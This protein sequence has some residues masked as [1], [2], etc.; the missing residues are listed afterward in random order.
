MRR[1]RAAVQAFFISILLGSSVESDPRTRRFQAHFRPGTATH[2]G[3]GARQMNHRC[4][5]GTA[6]RTKSRSQDRSCRAV[7]S[8]RRSTLRGGSARRPE[9]KV[10]NTW[11]PWRC[12]AAGESEI[13]HGRCRRRT[14]RSFVEA[15]RPGTPTIST[16]SSP[17]LI[18]TSSGIPPLSRPWRAG[19][20]PTRGHDGA[21]K[22]WD[23]YRGGAWERSTIRIQEIRDLGESV[24]VLG[25]I[26]LTARTTGIEFQPGSRATPHLPRRKA[27][28]RR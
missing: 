5:A 26:D 17:S 7:P 22:A 11:K 18:P 9:R 1:V 6:L 16:H 24:L 2:V 28:P 10:P 23:D 21:R 3:E 4:T 12:G 20:P 13:L 8:G 14:W 27:P 25:H 19:K 15:S